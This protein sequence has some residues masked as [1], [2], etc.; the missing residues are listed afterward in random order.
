M[1]LKANLSFSKA[2][3]GKVGNNGE[4]VTQKEIQKIGTQDFLEM[5]KLLGRRPKH[6][7]MYYTHT[8]IYTH[9]LRCALSHKQ[10]YRH[11]AG[12]KE[13]RTDVSKSSMNANWK[14]IVLDI[15]MGKTEYKQILTQQ[16]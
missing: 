7:H 6:A 4:S 8:P 14:L 13:G 5:C 3:V 1:E 11:H 2:L 9:L 10:M 16:N 15:L 12:T